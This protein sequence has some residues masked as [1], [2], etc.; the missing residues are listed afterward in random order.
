MLQGSK[1]LHEQCRAEYLLIKILTKYSII[2]FQNSPIQFISYTLKTQ[3]IFRNLFTKIRSILRL[4]RPN[5]MIPSTSTSSSYQQ[6]TINLAVEGMMCQKNCGSTVETSLRNMDLDPFISF[7]ERQLQEIS[8]QNITAASQV[9]VKV[10]SSVADF[11]TSFASVVI[12]WDVVPSQQQQGTDLLDDT[13]TTATDDIITIQHKLTTSLSTPEKQTQ[14]MDVLSKLAIEEI[15]CVGFDATWLSSEDDVNRHREGAGAAH[16]KDQKLKEEMDLHLRQDA[17]SDTMNTETTVGTVTATFHVGGMSCAVCTGSVERFLLSVG[18]N[19]NENDDEE[20][21]NDE[22]RPYVVNAAVSLPTNTA[23]VTFSKISNREIVNERQVYQDLAEECVSTVTRGGYACELLNLILPTGDSLQN[24]DNGGGGTSLID[25]AARMERSRQQELYEWKCSLII[26]LVFTLPLAICHFV[27]MGTMHSMEDMSDEEK[28]TSSSSLPP[29]K[30]DW[31]MLLLATP[32]QFGVGKRFYISAYR[33]LIHGCTM[34]MDFLVAMGTSSAYLYS[35]IV[36]IL[37][38]IAK[39]NG[40]YDASIMD[41]T[42]TFET[43]AWLITFVTLGKYLEAYARGKTA[44]AL[45]TLMELQPVSATRAILPDDV[46]KMMEEVQS[47][48]ELDTGEKSDNIMRIFSKVHVNSV[49]TEEKDI[50]EI[51]V[52]DFLLVL[53]GGRIPTDGILVARDVTGKLKDADNNSNNDGCAYID[54]SAFS[55]EPFPV[56]KRPGDPLYGASVNQLST[57]VIQVTAIGSETVLSRIVRLV[58]EAQGNRAPIQAHADRIASIFAPCVM[59]LAAITFTCWSVFLDPS[60][61]SIEERFVTALMSAI[62]VVVVAC[63]CA[64][65][66]ATPTAVMVGTGV[67]A[68]NGLLIKG[69][70]VLESAFN[71]KTVVVDKTGTITTGRAVVGSKIDYVSQLLEA[72]HRDDGGW[73][74]QLLNFVPAAV[75]QTDAALWFACCA[76]LRSEHPLGRAILNSGREIWGHDIL[77]PTSR[78]KGVAKQSGQ[79]KTISEFQVIPGSGVECTINETGHHCQVRVGNRS[80]VTDDIDA[81]TLSSG[82]ITS[83]ADDD[84]RSLRTEGQIGVYV[85]VKASSMNSFHIIGIIGILDPVKDE[86]KSTVTALKDL[87]VDVWM[88]T[89]DHELTAHAVARRI[90]IDEDNVCSSVSPEGKADL[91]HRLQKR[92]VKENNGRLVENRVA[93]VGD[94]INDAVALARSD[95]GIAIGAGTEVAVEAADIVLVRSQ[96]H[97]VVVALHLSRV[98]FDRIRLNFV[99]A[100]AYNLFAIPFA[101]GFLYPFTD[102]T[103]PPAFAGLMMAFSSVSVVMSSLLL[104]TYVKPTI[105]ED[106][107]MEERGCTRCTSALI[108]KCYSCI[109]GL[110]LQKRSHHHLINGNDDDDLEMITSMV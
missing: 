22:R 59:M 92:R 6:I 53:P 76:E 49:P 95:V 17:I 21:S 77:K 52:G 94:G 100:M 45:Q 25:S 35:I 15:E 99:W 36:F 107:T 79:E 88:C 65:G 30:M 27:T 102:W 26:S 51:Y 67:G 56:A 110:S 33:G 3:H 54:E 39:R 70:A 8:E 34:G 58:D 28:V 38:L 78:D 96:L 108:E 105:N 84:V 97:D 55:G 89:G 101:A 68:V 81:N 73:L 20:F 16:E 60:S 57:I 91:I 13:T 69:G 9:D 31:M 98:V 11:A 48:L 80:W 109:Y 2:S 86:A 93:F 14:L 74:D 90:G 85:S 4:S 12:Q 43:G 82:D 1:L 5:M 40:E 7:L 50:S 32:V 37:Q 23:R 63:P 18:G 29:T 66:L 83:R 42:P 72:E 103:L 10:I 46:L 106:G 87:G 24:D 71:V 19:H 62:S 61:G 41:L 44:G 75:R 104:R 64:L 47:S